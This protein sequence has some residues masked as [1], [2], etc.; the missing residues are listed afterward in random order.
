MLLRKDVVYWWNPGMDSLVFGLKSNMRRLSL[1][2]ASWDCLVETIQGF[3]SLKQNKTKQKN[4]NV[5]T[6]TDGIIS[7]P[8]TLYCFLS[9]FV[10]ASNCFVYFLSS[11]KADTWKRNY[12]CKYR[13]SK[14]QSMLL[15]YDARTSSIYQCC[16]L[17]QM[18]GWWD[19]Q[20]HPVDVGMMSQWTR[21]GLQNENGGN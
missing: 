8:D 13:H 21:T 18:S 5:T 3:R 6:V 1:H 19:T 10:Q 17:D 12:R 11:A 20:Y 7:L 14:C 9:E 4:N 15:S 2:E 16:W